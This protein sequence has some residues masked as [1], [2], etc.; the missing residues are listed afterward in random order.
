[1]PTLLTFLLRLLLLAAGLL[2]AASLAVVA[3]L[4]LGLW[5][6][7]AAWAKLTGRPVVPFIF[8]IDRRSGFERMYRRAQRGT[9]TPRADAVMPGRKISDVIDVEPRPQSESRS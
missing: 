2:F 6:V 7:R 9:R 3:V 8:R 1:M 4:M 5:G